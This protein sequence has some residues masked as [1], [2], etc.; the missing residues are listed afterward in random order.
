MKLGS[1]FVDYENIYYYLKQRISDEYDAAELSTDL[2]RKL[3]EKLLKEN[4]IHCIVQHAY[5]D[6]ERIGNSVQGGLYLTG[7]VTH[8]VLGTEHKN[9]ADMQMC[10]DIME[11]LHTRKEIN[12]FIIVAGDR[13]YIPVINYLKTHAKHVTIVSFKGSASGDLLQVAEERNFLS[14]DTLL[15]PAILL[16]EPQREPVR[17]AP[18]SLPD[19]EYRPAITFE[20]KEFEPIKELQTDN[21]MEALEILL[22]YFKDKQEV[23]MT[24]YLNKL[25][26]YMPGLVDFERKAII[27]DLVQFGAIKVEKRDG[28]PNPFSV[29]IVN[30]NHPNVRE[31][32]P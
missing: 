26:T 4:D 13:D 17:R 30:W 2:L 20:T 21:Q 15:D 11:V 31:L 23:W 12:N 27:S 10:I 24:P 1:L 19:A 7:I 16:S 6:F 3:R 32:A 29:I 25:R 14:L 9:A 8:N 22:T 28:E 5:G 18:A